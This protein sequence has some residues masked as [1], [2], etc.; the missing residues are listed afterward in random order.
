MSEALFTKNWQNWVSKEINEKIPDIALVNLLDNN[1]KYS[2]NGS[3][4]IINLIKYPHKVSLSITSHLM[5]KPENLDKGSD[6]GFQAVEKIL[7]AHGARFNQIF[8]DSAII[9]IEF[10]T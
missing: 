1:L 3:E 6:I 2:P 7:S 5:K 10:M 4:V 9:S 8:H